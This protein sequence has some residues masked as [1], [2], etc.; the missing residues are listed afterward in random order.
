MD[1]GC[2]L[3]LLP[4]QLGLTHVEFGRVRVSHKGKLNACFIFQGQ[5]RDPGR[6]LLHTLS[7]TVQQRPVRRRI[8]EPGLKQQILLQYMP[9][10]SFAQGLAQ[11]RQVLFVNARVYFL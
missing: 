2:G 3:E 7:Q 6:E 5:S 10:A 8:H 9:Q 4:Y 1:A 11:L